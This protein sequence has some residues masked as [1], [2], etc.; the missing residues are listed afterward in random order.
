MTTMNKLP[1]LYQKCRIF[2]SY[3]NLDIESLAEEYE[4]IERIICKS[5]NH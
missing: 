5:I 1:E 2:E 4:R 3:G